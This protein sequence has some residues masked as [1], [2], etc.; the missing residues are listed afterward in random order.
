[1]EMEALAGEFA[2][3]DCRILVAV[4]NLRAR[5]HPR[6]RALAEAISSVQV[7]CLED[8]S[9]L[10][11][12]HRKMQVGD[13]RLPFVVCMDQQGRGVYANAN[14]QIRLAQTL[15]KIQKLLARGDAQENQDLHG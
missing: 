13:L 2:S 9:A 8:R 3:L 7:L 4:D 1:M 6:L 5:K 11:Y 12:L 10:S 14:Y 15:L